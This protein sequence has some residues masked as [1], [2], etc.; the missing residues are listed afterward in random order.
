M[1]VCHYYSIEMPGWE[2]FSYFS[3]VRPWSTNTA[4]Q[5]KS[6]FTG[7]LNSSSI[8]QPPN[9]TRLH[10]SGSCSWKEG[11]EYIYL[12]FHFQEEGK[13]PKT[14]WKMAGLTDVVFPVDSHPELSGTR[15]NSAPSLSVPQGPQG[16]EVS[17]SSQGK[18]V[19]VFAL[20]TSPGENGLPMEDQIKDPKVQL[21]T[22]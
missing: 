21:E 18:G 12:G 2:L 5:T 20:S 13:S 17:T 19:G 14:L 7:K 6:V 11:F 8:Q 10:W 1:T 22:K 15:G 4:Y 3:L 16:A 9:S